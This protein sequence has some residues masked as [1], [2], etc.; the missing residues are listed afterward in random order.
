[1]KNIKELV[2]E[3]ERKCREKTKK[4]R[5]QKEENNKKEFSKELPGRIIAKML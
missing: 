5:Q 4:V 1:L 2:E 3:F